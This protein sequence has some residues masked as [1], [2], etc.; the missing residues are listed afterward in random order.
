MLIFNAEV[1][2]KEAATF[3]STVGYTHVW[4]SRHTASRIIH[5]CLKAQVSCQSCTQANLLPRKELAISVGLMAGWVQL[6]S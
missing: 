2:C 4:G 3:N 1:N 6:K 5:L